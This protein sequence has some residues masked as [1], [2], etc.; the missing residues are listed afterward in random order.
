MTC[1]V[2]PQGSQDQHHL[3]SCLRNYCV[4]LGIPLS[5]ALELFYICGLRAIPKYGILAYIYMYIYIYVCVC[6]LLSLALPVSLSL[7]MYIYVCLYTHLNRSTQ[8]FIRTRSLPYESLKNYV[9]SSGCGAP[10]SGCGPALFLHP[11][12][13][14][15]T[16]T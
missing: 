9:A 11:T 3:P 5:S 14:V 7:S 15:V 4:L 2:D 6:L 16:S 10:P 1:G 8:M 13:N 12:L